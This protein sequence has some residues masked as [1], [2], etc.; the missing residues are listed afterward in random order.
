MCASP[1]FWEYNQCGERVMKEKLPRVDLAHMLYLQ[2]MLFF[3]QPTADII[4]QVTLSHSIFPL[5]GSKS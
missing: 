1:R 5:R 3:N 4:D 2:P